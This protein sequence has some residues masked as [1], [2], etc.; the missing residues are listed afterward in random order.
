MWD[1][2]YPDEIYRLY[3]GPHQ[4]ARPKSDFAKGAAGGRVSVRAE[5]EGKFLAFLRA[6]VGTPLFLKDDRSL[7]SDDP[8]I[9]RMRAMLHQHDEPGRRD[10]LQ[11]LVI[12]ELEVTLRRV[13]EFLTGLTLGGQA[14]G[15]S[16]SNALYMDVLLKMV[17]STSSEVETN[18]DS[19]RERIR[20]VSL[21]APEH[22][23]YGLMPPLDFD[24][25][26]RLL[27]RATGPELQSLVQRVFEPYVSSL[28]GRLAALKDAYSTLDA[29]VPT[30]NSFFEGK[31][32]EFSPR[33]G[34]EILAKGGGALPVASLSSGER[35]LLALL[36]NT[37]LARKESRLF[38][39]DEPELSLGVDWQR[40]IIR[41]LMELT[42]GTVVQ[43]VVATHSIE[44]VTSEPEALVR[45]E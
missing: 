8:D 34:L 20:E 42:Q 3:A 24:E 40:R 43:F 4:R 44:I 11:R 36:L 25:F 9:E 7:G 27:N 37:L 33:N 22:E 2:E 38:L 16:T 10:Q 30:L 39:I 45:L 29:L 41:A 21:V 18:L 17:N 14:D 28:E 31:S 23:K 1:G 6:E 15:S 35:H 12:L 32:V 13:N 19:L 26:T 5:Q